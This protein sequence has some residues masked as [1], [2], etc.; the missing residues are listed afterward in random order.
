MRVGGRT[1]CRAAGRAN[2]IKT[3]EGDDV[4]GWLGEGERARV[5][6]P[7]ERFIITARRGPR[8][9]TKKEERDA[10]SPSE[11]GRRWIRPT[12]LKKEGAETGHQEGSGQE[13]QQQAGK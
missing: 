3:H 12:N 8:R 11:S 2:G 10:C 5:K 4:V 7:S 13:Q 1:D 9:G 6:R